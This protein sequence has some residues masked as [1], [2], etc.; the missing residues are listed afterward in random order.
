MPS[1]PGRPGF[2]FG[3]GDADEIEKLEK[4]KKK[5][6]TPQRNRVFTRV[7]PGH[8]LYVGQ[9]DVSFTAALSKEEWKELDPRVHRT[10]AK[11]VCEKDWGKDQRARIILR[12]RPGKNRK[13]TLEETDQLWN[14]GRNFKGEV[15]PVQVIDSFDRGEKFILV[16]T[17]ECVGYEYDFQQ[18]LVSDQPA[19]QADRADQAASK[20]RKQKDRESDQEDAGETAKRARR[21]T[22]TE[23]KN[24]ALNVEVGY[25]SRGT[26]S[27]PSRTAKS[28]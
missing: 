9:Y 27:R 4:K 13:F 25:I 26:R 6:G 10:W 8:W 22:V 5:T 18:K 28:A 11:G 2:F 14:S 21:I 1:L 19:W 15:I 24:R 12:N 23:S 17:M 3:N 7:E 16:Y 20:K